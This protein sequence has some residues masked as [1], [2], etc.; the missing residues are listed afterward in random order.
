MNTSELIDRSLFYSLRKQWEKALDFAEQAL[1]KDPKSFLAH[2]RLSLCLWYTD[3]K[4]EAIASMHKSLEFYPEFASAHYN[5][6]CFY[7]QQEDKEKML[8]HLNQAIALEE[9]TDYHQ[10]AKD[11]RDFRGYRKDDDFLAIVNAN[12]EKEDLI[13]ATLSGEDYEAISN[14]LLKIE[15]EIPVS[16]IEWEDYYGDDETTLPYLLASKWDKISE[17]ALFHV[18][19]IVS[20]NLDAED[21]TGL[22]PLCHAIKNRIP[23]NYNNFFIEAWKNKYSYIDAKHL[24][25]LDRNFLTLI[26]ELPVEIITDVIVWA[27]NSHGK[28]ALEDYEELCAIALQD[29]PENHEAHD[30]LINSID[31]LMHDNQYQDENISDKKQRLVLSIA[32]PPLKYPEGIEG[33]RDKLQFKFKQDHPYHIIN[34]AAGLA[35]H[36]DFIHL[37][38]PRLPEIA[39]LANLNI[40]SPE[41][42]LQAISEVLAKIG[43]KEEIALLSPCLQDKSYQ[44]LKTVG[45]LFYEHEIVAEE[46]SEAVD[47]LI[48]STQIEDIDAYELHDIIVA[49][50]WFKDERIT[51]ILL[52][53]LDYERELVAREA[54]KGL[55]TQKAEK[56]IPKII[57]Q[58]KSGYPQCVSAAAQAL[59]DIGGIAHLELEKRSNFDIVMAR[60]QKSPR[61][62]TRALP[63]FNIKGMDTDLIALLKTNKENEAYVHITKAIAQRGTQTIFPDLLAIG[64]DM[65]N[66]RNIGG[67]NFVLMFNTII[68]NTSDILNEEVMNQCKEVLVNTDTEDITAFINILERDG[69]YARLKY[70]NEEEQTIMD[71]FVKKYAETL[72]NSDLINVLFTA[73]YYS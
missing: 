9:Y 31:T 61:W 54:L 71:V 24:S 17:E 51:D 43:S 52:N 4:E 2:K 32:P 34:G 60:A 46:A 3:K 35:R 66:S 55:G 63:Y 62:A 53:F 29:L 58:F 23:A 48:A 72:E 27:L 64:L 33:F 73:K 6:A 18:F 45:Q 70:P 67:R 26:A 42:R 57:N 36:H 22:V 37:V 15:R 59:N 40:L 11:D 12:N 10:M 38:K 47:Y 44:L 21:F 14:L 69:D 7:A 5:L 16:I 13:I 19:K 50:R 68:R 56:A 20:Q 49:L 39:N 28:D 8:H 65:F 1:A 41:L 30:A 25:R